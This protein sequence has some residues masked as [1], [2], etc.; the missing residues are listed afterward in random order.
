MGKFKKYFKFWALALAFA[1]ITIFT[2]GTFAQV[3]VSN[4]LTGSNLALVTDIMDGAGTTG[5]SGIFTLIVTVWNWLVA[6]LAIVVLVLVSL[7][8][9]GKAKRKARSIT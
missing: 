7:F 9:W 5:A 6:N 3:T 8:F 2:T 4:V 1:F